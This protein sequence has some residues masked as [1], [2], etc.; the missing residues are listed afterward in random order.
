VGRAQ[1][2]AVLAK[3]RPA[4]LALSI[5]KVMTVDG[6]VLEKHHI[7]VEAALQP[8]TAFLVNQFSRGVSSAKRLG[9]RAI[10]FSLDGGR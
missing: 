2:Y 3:P 8:A 9:A 7:G 4:R 6:R 5:K 10:R 1:V